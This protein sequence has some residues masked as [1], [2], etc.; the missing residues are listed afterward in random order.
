MLSVLALRRR[1]DIVK[2]AAA[3]SRRANEAHSDRK[4]LPCLFIRGGKKKKPVQQP[5]F[6]RHCAMLAHQSRNNINEGMHSFSG[7][8]PPPPA[9]RHSVLTDKGG[10]VKGAIN[11]VMSTYTH[12]TQW[13]LSPSGFFFF[14]TTLCVMYL[15][16]IL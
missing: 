5:S 7:S 6:A 14:F 16:C 3:V 1:P 8:T 11:G 15:A 12:A 4:A 10:C 9:S 13:F 2:F